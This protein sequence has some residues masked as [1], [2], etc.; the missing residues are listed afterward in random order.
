M[1]F[2]DLHMVHSF[3]HLAGSQLLFI[4][5]L[6]D[7]QG[8]PSPS[9]IRGRTQ[10][11]V[12]LVWAGDRMAS[13]RKPSIEKHE[14]LMLHLLKDWV[15][16]CVCVCVC[17]PLCV[18]MCGASIVPRTAASLTSCEA[19]VCV[20]VCICVCVFCCILQTSLDLQRF[21]KALHV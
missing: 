16:V 21:G 18:C 9:G 1:L 3:L 10:S 12:W 5:L 20:R 17:V 8:P 19:L 15:S 11:V 2:I 6:I 4:A 13:S 7:D 14:R